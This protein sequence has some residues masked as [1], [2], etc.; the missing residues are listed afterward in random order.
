M[1]ARA[2]FIDGNLRDTLLG[3]SSLGLAGEFHTNARHF[4]IEY[5]S[6]MRQGRLEEKMVLPASSASRFARTDRSG[7]LS[8]LPLRTSFA[9]PLSK[10]VMS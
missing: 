10:N 7:S 4:D 5:L 2:L 6:K 9:P 3:S 8:E 1:T